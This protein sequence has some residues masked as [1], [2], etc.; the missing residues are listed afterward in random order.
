MVFN[1]SDLG[2]KEIANH[3]SGD[4]DLNIGGCMWFYMVREQRP[5]Q[6]I[7]YNQSTHARIY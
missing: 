4:S 6:M 5:V 3:W 7:P 2:R 1:N